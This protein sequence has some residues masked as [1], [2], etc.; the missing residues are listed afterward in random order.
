M[1]ITYGGMI[2]KIMDSFY[3]NISKPKKL[4]TFFY[5]D[6]LKIDTNKNIFRM[7]TR[8]AEGSVVSLS[9]SDASAE[10]GAKENTQCEPLVGASV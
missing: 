1:S 7:Q 9:P 8:R 2:P 4:T 6:P 5:I 10:G 3:S